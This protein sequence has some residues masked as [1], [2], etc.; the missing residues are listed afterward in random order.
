MTI[1]S[2]ESMAAQVAVVPQDRDATGETASDGY[3]AAG[4]QPRATTAHP[5][6][7][8]GDFLKAIKSLGYGPD[9]N[10]APLVADASLK[11]RPRVHHR[12]YVSCPLE[13]W[14]EVF[15]NPKGIEEYG[16]RPKSRLPLNVWQH[17][18]ADGPIM[19]IGHLFER[20]PG[21]PWVVTFRVSVL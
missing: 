19:C 21:V 7:S 20:S 8:Q 11:A 9:V 10:H 2:N 18:C 5:R 6:R 13:T 3:P 14:T 16:G 4:A 15:G 12:A 1:T 17:S